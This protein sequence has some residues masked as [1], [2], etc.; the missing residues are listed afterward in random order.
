MHHD[1]GGGGDSVNP[2]AA[3]FAVSAASSRTGRR[4]L[5]CG[6]A[7]LAAM[8][9]LPFAVAAA[10]S[11]GALDLTPAATAT[12]GA[13]VVGSGEPLPPAT[14]RVSQG[15]GCTAVA[16]EGPPPR[17]YSCPPDGAHRDATRFHS[18]IDM[19]APTGTPVYAVAAGMLHVV[20]DRAGFGLHELLV[21][22]GATYLYG[23]LSVAL[24]ADGG[25]VSAGELI[26]F[27]GS[28]GNSSGPHLHFEVDVGGIPVNPCAVFPAGYLAPAGTAAL[29]CLADELA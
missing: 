28:S 4:L 7:G 23:H 13:L 10:L 24:V 14:F 21:A 9:A 29:D 8:A 3:R 6:C 15:F 1:A 16:L 5:G 2:V 20:A 11:T 18:G 22:G 19:A 26:G 12:S 27:V 17:P 25:T